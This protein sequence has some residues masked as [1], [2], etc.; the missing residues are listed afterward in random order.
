MGEAR[1]V[2]QGNWRRKRYGKQYGNVR[3]NGQRGWRH[4]M[5]WIPAGVDGNPLTMAPP[6][7]GVMMKGFSC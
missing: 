2:V 1:K 3:K 4:A 7:I 5:A 6:E